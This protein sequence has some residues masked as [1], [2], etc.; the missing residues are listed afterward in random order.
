[1]NN[2]N[3][4]KDNDNPKQKSSV[5]SDLELEVIYDIVLYKITF[6]KDLNCH[7]TIWDDCLTYLD[8]LVKHES[9]ELYVCKIKN[10]LREISGTRKPNNW[11]MSVSRSAIISTQLYII[12]YYLYRDNR[13]YTDIILPSLKEI[14]GYFKNPSHGE[15]E[16]IQKLLQKLPV[17]KTPVYTQGAA[18]D[19]KL[20]Q[21]KEDAITELKKEI[22]KLTEENVLLREEN[23]KLKEQDDPED[24]IA[25]IE[26]GQGKNIKPHKMTAR[27]AVEIVADSGKSSIMS[28]EEWKLLLSKLTGL[29]E[30]SFNRYMSLMP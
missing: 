21:E 14:M 16:Y 20:L 23:K 30:A 28:K 24:E 27:K 10:E 7:D 1:M 19:S 15:Y 9:P 22:A 6:F 12:L 25:L 17:R 11:G 5:I 8:R 3:S 2:M 18:V 4:N 13:T 29:S 26:R